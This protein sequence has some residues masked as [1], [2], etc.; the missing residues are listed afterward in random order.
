MKGERISDD[1]SRVHEELAE[2]FV[3]RIWRI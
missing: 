3:V 1:S 2:K